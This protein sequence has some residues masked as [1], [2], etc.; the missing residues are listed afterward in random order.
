MCDYFDTKNIDL[1]PLIQKPE[2]WESYSETARVNYQDV[3]KPKIILS[4]NF[5]THI[6]KRIPGSL[7][8]LTIEAS[9]Y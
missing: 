2:I 8:R 7:S 9:K 3:A 4:H 6:Q 5:H 1:G